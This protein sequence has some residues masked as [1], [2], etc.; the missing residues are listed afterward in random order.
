MYGS[1]KWSSVKHGWFCLVLFGLARHGYINMETLELVIQLSKLVG[2]V[3]I[4]TLL[5]L[6]WRELHT[7]RIANLRRR[8]K[9][10]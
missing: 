8:R 4:V 3:I 1:A 5:F 7:I 9:Y 6:I 10:E 2:G